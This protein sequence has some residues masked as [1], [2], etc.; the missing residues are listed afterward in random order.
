MDFFSP[1]LR[2]A[3]AS[4][5]LFGAEQRSLH[6]RVWQDAASACGLQNVGFPKWSR[7]SA[8][9]GPMSVTIEKYGAEQSTQ[10]VV[11]VPGP[12]DFQRVSIRRESLLEEGRGIEIGEP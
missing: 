7:L 6:L 2:I 9:A 8:R 4:R 11:W 3:I 5:N 12:P 1:I 10:I